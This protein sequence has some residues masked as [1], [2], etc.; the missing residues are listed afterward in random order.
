MSLNLGSLLANSARCYPGE[1][2]TY[3]HLQQYTYEE[4]DARARRFA[5]SLSRAGLEHG[6]TVALAAPNEPRFTIA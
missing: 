5:H 1:R 2:A 6:D 3:F 4:L